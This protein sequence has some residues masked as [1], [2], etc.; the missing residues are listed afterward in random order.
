MICCHNIQNN[1]IFSTLTRDFSQEL[2]VLPV[3]DM[4]CAV[5]KC[6]SSESVLIIIIII[7]IIIFI[8]CNCVFTRWQWLFYTYTNMKKVT[9]KFKYGGLDERHVVATWKLG[10][11]LSIRL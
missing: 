9:R 4:Q 7:I 6:R 3:D 11:H 8:N 10:K 2:Y 1:G 5:E